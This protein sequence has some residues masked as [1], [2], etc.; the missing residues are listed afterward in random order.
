MDYFHL[1]WSNIGADRTRVME[2]VMTGYMD[3][4]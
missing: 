2:M 1:V 4:V 3:G